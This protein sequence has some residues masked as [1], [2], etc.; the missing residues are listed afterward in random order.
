MTMSVDGSGEGTNRAPE[1]SVSSDGVLGAATSTI[2]ISPAQARQAFFVVPVRTR[3]QPSLAEHHSVERIAQFHRCS[4]GVQ[5]IK[6]KI[7]QQIEE[8]RRLI[9]DGKNER[10]PTQLLNELTIEL[11][12]AGLGPEREELSDKTVI[13]GGT[14]GFLQDH[15]SVCD[16]EQLSALGRIFDDAVAALPEEM[17]TP[18]YRTEVAKLILGRAVINQL[19]P[20]ALIRIVIAVAS[21]V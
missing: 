11:I 19:E 3:Q 12:S 9:D 15:C 1:M 4:S 8:I 18:F 10:E 21:A 14:G 13:G 5:R 20:G 17:R 7:G 2:R 16:P 6:Q